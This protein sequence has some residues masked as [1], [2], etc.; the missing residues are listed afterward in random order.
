[1]SDIEMILDQLGLQEGTQE[2][3]DVE[4][5]LRNRLREKLAALRD[6]ATEPLPQDR[7]IGAASLNGKHKPALGKASVFSLVAGSNR[8]TPSTRNNAGSTP[9]A[10]AAKGANTKQEREKPV[11][12][13]V[14]VSGHLIA[15]GRIDLERSG[16]VFL[17][18]E[19]ETV[20]D[21]L[22]LDNARAQIRGVDY[23]LRKETG[24]F[25]AGMASAF[26]VPETLEIKGLK[27]KKVK[28][29][30]KAAS[31]RSEDYVKISVETGP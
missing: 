10:L 7:P 18:I 16:K 22:L 17:T 8:G 1:M 3:Q 4:R 5:V 13:A 23:V 27:W 20:P 11:P 25:A 24:A 6:A 30:F 31:S 14:V 29:T 28:D 2:R 21:G 19:R 9:L 26:R 12:A 15:M